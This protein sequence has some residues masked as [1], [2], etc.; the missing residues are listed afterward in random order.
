MTTRPTEGATHYEVLGLG[1]GAS[2]EDITRTYRGLA[3][4]WHS[5]AGSREE[6]P[7]RDAEMRRLTEARSVL[8]DPVARQAY[9]RSLGHDSSLLVEG[10][11]YVF[12]VGDLVFRY[13]P[14]STDEAERWA[15]AWESL[16]SPD[17][18]EVARIW[19]GREREREREAGPGRRREAANRRMTIALLTLVLLLETAVLV[20]SLWH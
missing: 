20:L 7:C 19:E 4:Q 18:A 15:A 16:A 2:P 5:D 1:F 12:Y 14:S 13:V 6:A 17:E 11:T 8:A 3:K 10:G 9:D